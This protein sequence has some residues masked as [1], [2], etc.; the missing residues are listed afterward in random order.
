VLFDERYLDWATGLAD[1]GTTFAGAHGKRRGPGF[2]FLERSAMIG[3]G[4]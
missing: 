2:F 1:D 3:Y 4:L